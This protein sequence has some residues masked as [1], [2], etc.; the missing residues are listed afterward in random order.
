MM[1]TYLP[2]VRSRTGKSFGPMTIS[3]TMAS[4]RSLLEVMSNI[5][6]P[7]RKALA[8]V[9]PGAGA[10]Q[11]SGSPLIFREARR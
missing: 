2:M 5:S 4:S 1:P 7:L 3:A 9:P 6:H 11:D 10:R 8:P